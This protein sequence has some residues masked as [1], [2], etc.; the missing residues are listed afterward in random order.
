MPKTQG[1]CRWWQHLLQQ[2]QTMNLWC[3]GAFVCLL[4]LHI[5][6][7]LTIK[8][9]AAVASTETEYFDLE[10]LD[11]NEYYVPTFT[12]DDLES[13][14]VESKTSKDIDV[15]ICKASESWQG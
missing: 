3:F 13:L 8:V 1:D 9:A 6:S 15:D 14:R 12:Q 11:Y 10:S 5:S 7:Q 4:L 2:Q